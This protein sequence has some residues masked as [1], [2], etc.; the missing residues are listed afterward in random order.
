MKLHRGVSQ[1]WTATRQINLYR[2]PFIS[3]IFAFCAVA[4]SSA[5][6]AAQQP[7][8]PTLQVCNYTYVDADGEIEIISRADSSHTGASK[9]M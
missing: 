8:I 3:Y 5:N 4:L 9:C 2:T 6:T 7:Q 1:L